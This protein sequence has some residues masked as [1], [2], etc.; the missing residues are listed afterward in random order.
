MV[1]H[2]MPVEKEDNRYH[3]KTYFEPNIGLR[4]RTGILNSDG[5]DTKEDPFQAEYP[6][7]MD[8]GIMEQCACVEV[9]KVDCYQKAIA[10]TGKNMSVEDFVWL[11]EQSRGKT[12][13]VALGG[14]GDP[15][16]HENFADIL[17]VCAENN[18]VPNFTTSGIA[19][20]PEKAKLCRRY[21]GAVAVSE[22]NA[23]YTAKAVEFLT[24]AGVKT[25]IHYV[26]NRNTIEKA[27]EILRG[28]RYREGINA[29]VF[30]L[31]KP[32]GLGRQELVL[33]PDD[34]RLTIKSQ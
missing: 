34:E 8:I 15:D 28:G 20:T 17:R 18:I 12:L 25:N 2:Y 33:Q 1:Y 16:T 4:I 19:M 14:A 10:R 11:I 30:L 7:L 24:A 9:C 5:V 31:Y 3:F 22:H 29:V 21:C 27:T 6:E 32:V 26:L 13:Q 23:A